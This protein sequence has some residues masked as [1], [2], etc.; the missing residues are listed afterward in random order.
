M[1]Q[2]SLTSRFLIALL[3]LFLTGFLAIVGVNAVISNLIDDLDAQSDN[4]RARLFIG[5]HIANTIRQIESHFFQFSV[6]SEATR[7]RLSRDILRS[8]NELEHAIHVLQSGG[9]VTKRLYLNI[10]G[11]DETV[12]QEYYQPDASAS[13][14]VLEVIEIS[15]YIDQLRTRLATLDATL[16]R[17]EHC[18]ENDVACF[19]TTREQLLYQYKSIPSFFFRLN[20]NANRLFFVGNN[21]LQALEQKLQEQKRNLLHTQLAIVVLVVLTVMLL[22][23]LAMRRIEATQAHIE[24]AREAAEAANIAKSQFLANISH[25]IRTPMN[26]IIGMTELLLESPLDPEQTEQLSIVRN[27]ANHLLQII[28]DILDFSKIESTQIELESIPLSLAD[29]CHESLEN[30]AVRARA[31]GLQIRETIPPDLPPQLL[32]DPVRLRQ[33]LL[34]LLGNAVKFTDRGH[35]ALTVDSVPSEQPDI[36]RVQITVSD[37]GIGIPEDKLEEVFKAFTQVDASTTRRYGGTGLG[38]T[39]CRRLVEQMHGEIRIDSVLGQGTRFVVTLALP[40][41]PEQVS[42]PVDVVQPAEKA[43]PL[44][45]LLVEDTVLNQRVASKLLGNWGHHVTIADHGGKAL[46]ILNEHTFDLI[47]MDMQMPIM[48]GIEATEKIRAREA[49]TG[50]TP[51]CIFAMTAN[52]AEGDRQRCLEAGMNDFVTKPI[53]AQAL[54]ALLART[55]PADT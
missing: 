9:V 50:Q 3:A 30:I 34:N 44:N 26:G 37:S 2:R 17:Q 42:A 33:I 35:I 20:E 53:N 13:K 52:A 47:L 5:E 51:A 27:S 46:D 1:I 16:S 40:R 54:Q 41:V 29:L 39:I 18:A 24:R 49:R 43:R 32:G 31:K 14:F 8:T 10:E 21:Q 38:L 36:F 11:Y 7:Q 4:E 12:R 6:A 28:N 45:I 22:G 55:F 19:R 15:P 25:E 23:W 48:D